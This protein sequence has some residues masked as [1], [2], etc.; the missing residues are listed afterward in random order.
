V[1][2]RL[3]TT[4]D[5]DDGVPDDGRVAVRARHEAVLPDG[6]RLLLLDDR[7]WASSAAW[8][9]VSVEDVEETTRTVVGPDEPAEGATWQESQADHWSHLARTL[10]AYGVG[11]DAGE[12]RRLPHE[13]V[14]CDRLRARIARG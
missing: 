1:V 12:L 10:Q 13:L 11:V 6:R 9:A 4:A 14:L 2:E 7:G 5:V 3:V 8:T